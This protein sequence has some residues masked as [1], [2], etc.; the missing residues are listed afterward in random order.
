MEMIGGYPNKEEKNQFVE[1][2]LCCYGKDSKWDAVQP[3][4]G[5]TT[6]EAVECVEEYLM[7]DFPCVEENWIKDE[8]GVKVPT[9][10]WGGGDS[11]DREKVCEIFLAKEVA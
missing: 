7:G 5:M 2:V 1:Y 8:F 6:I 9:H 11:I 4:V 3:D 10:L